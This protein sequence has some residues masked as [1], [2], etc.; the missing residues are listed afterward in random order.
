MLK[1]RRGALQAGKNLD[2]ETR[3]DLVDLFY[4]IDSDRGGCIGPNEAA[5]SIPEVR[6]RWTSLAV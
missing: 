5:Q 6:C 2:K 3:M 1:N 4:F